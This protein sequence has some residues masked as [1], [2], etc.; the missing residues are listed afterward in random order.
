V[1]W[2]REKSDVTEFLYNLLI[3]EAPS[4]GYAREVADR[5][6]VPYPTLAK[7]WLGRQRFPAALVGPLFRATG[8]DPRVAEFFLLRETGYRLERKQPLQSRLDVAQA[9]MTIAD[10][11]GR[12]SGIY[13]QVTSPGSDG[14]PA[15]TRREAEDLT[16]A[17]RALTRAT[18]ELVAAVDGRQ[19]YIGAGIFL[20]GE[21]S[22]P[23]LFPMSERNDLELRASVGSSGPAEPR[24]LSRISPVLWPLVVYLGL[25]TFLY[26]AVSQLERLAAAIAPWDA[27]GKRWH[28]VSPGWI[29]IYPVA[30][31]LLVLRGLG[32]LALAVPAR[33]FWSGWRAVRHL[34][35]AAV[36]AYRLVRRLVARALEV[37][38][39]KLREAMD[40]VRQASRAA[41]SRVQALLRSLRLR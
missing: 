35:L 41:V 6:G 21:G 28:E 24:D 3:A 39:Q 13:L 30:L 34:A 16:Q 11:G 5:M 7:Y 14:G 8:E 15:M 29:A 36:D 25:G 2:R 23:H 10:L 37:A 22:R 19:G 18:E 38:R 12:L 4:K 33:L 27:E 40:A 31:P 9:V 1:W 26:W 20:A 17:A 32:L